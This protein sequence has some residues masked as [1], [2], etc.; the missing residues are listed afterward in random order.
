[1]NWIHFV[2]VMNHED[3][4][5]SFVWLIYASTNSK[6]LIKFAILSYEPDAII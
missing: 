3:V 4:F 1:M 5:S 6:Y 2:S